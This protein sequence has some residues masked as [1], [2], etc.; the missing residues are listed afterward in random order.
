MTFLATV[1]TPV[2]EAILVDQPWMC[3]S[4]NSLRPMSLWFSREVVYTRMSLGTGIVSKS[5]AQSSLPITRVTKIYPEF[6]SKSVGSRVARVSS[7]L[8][9]CP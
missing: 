1:A 3:K 7:G 6:G 9:H 2:P 8:F 5:P 4:E